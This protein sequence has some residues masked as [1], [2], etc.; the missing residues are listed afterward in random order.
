MLK[1]IAK[2]ITKEV[3]QAK[4][5]VEQAY[6]IKHSHRELADLFISLASEELVHAEKLFRSGFTMISAKETGLYMTNDA[7]VKDQ[8][9]AHFEKCKTIWEW[10]NRLMS[11][12]MAE[13]KYKIS[14]FK[15]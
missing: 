10:E 1:K 4:D 14:M 9:D 7:T 8:S 6:L 2:R 12:T 13:L 11:D 5:Y 3:E 15:S